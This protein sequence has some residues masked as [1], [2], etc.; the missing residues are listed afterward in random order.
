MKAHTTTQANSVL[1]VDDHEDTRH[2]S[3]LVLQSQGFNASAAAGGD[4]AFAYACEE[5]PDVIVTDLAMP[6]GDGW[7]LIEKLSSDPRTREIPVVMLTA[8]ATESVRRRAEERGLAAFFFKPCSPDA[9]AAAMRR[10]A[11]ARRANVA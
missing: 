3:L 11:A 6:A 7:E 9:L 1:I 5:Q 4:A 10:L 8:C 2:M